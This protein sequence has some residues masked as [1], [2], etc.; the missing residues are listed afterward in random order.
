MDH[1]DNPA[2]RLYLIL[3]AVWSQPPNTGHGAAWRKAL[4]AEDAD[5]ST[6]LRRM[7]S[8][9]RLPGQVRSLVAQVDAL[10][11]MPPVESSLKRAEKVLG[12]YYAN[13]VEWFKKEMVSLDILQMVSGNLSTVFAEPVIED[14]R[15]EGF[16][17]DVATLYDDVQKADGLNDNERDHLL[18]ILDV[19]AEAIRDIDAGGANVVETAAHQALGEFV[20]GV[21]RDERHSDL[22]TSVLSLILTI[23]NSAAPMAWTAAQIPPTVDWYFPQAEVR[24]LVTREVESDMIDVEGAVPLIVEE[25]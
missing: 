2:G 17:E 14:E 1:R 24:Q 20:T 15:L 9:Y 5:E 10:R 7:S 18:N 23:L 16:L 4:K 8:V 11:E 25:E 3:Q 19:L 12:N 6:F 22:K 13:K 21:S